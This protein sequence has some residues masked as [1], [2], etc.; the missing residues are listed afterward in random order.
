MSRDAGTL[1]W[2]LTVAMMTS[3]IVLMRHGSTANDGSWQFHVSIVHSTDGNC[4][5]KTDVELELQGP[6][7]ASSRADVC[8]R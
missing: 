2:L 6:R 1:G 8:V 7:P 3:A 4:R 5:S